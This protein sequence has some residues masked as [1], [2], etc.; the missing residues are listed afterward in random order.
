MRVYTRF[1]STTPASCFCISLRKATR[2]LSARYDAALAPHAI[3]VAQFS[4]IRNIARRP[5]LSL[6]ELAEVAELDRSTIGRN[7]RVLERMGLVVLQQGK[8][9]QREATL[10]LTAAGADLLATT[11]PIW[12]NVQAEI[13]TALGPVQSAELTQLLAVL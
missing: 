5:G 6:T 8:A 9:D 10:A 11:T 2:R 1:M 7:V 13:A 4:L 3:N 12:E